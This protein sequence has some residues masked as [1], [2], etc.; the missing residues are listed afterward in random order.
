MPVVVGVGILLPGRGQARGP[1]IH[2][3]TAPCPYA[4]LLRLLPCHSFLD[5]VVGAGLRA[6]GLL[7]FPQKR[8]AARAY[9]CGELEEWGVGGSDVG[10]AVFNCG[11]R[12]KDLAFFVSP[13]EEAAAIA[14]GVAI[15]V[16]AGV[17]YPLQ[18]EGKGDE[19]RFEMGEF[20]GKAYVYALF[21][22]DGT[23]CML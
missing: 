15:V 13:E 11:E 23:A 1:R 8:A 16:V 18:E 6:S 4:A 12:E 2:T 10:C 5:R 20:A 22:G 19:E 7:Y 3:T 14:Q 21:A 9:S 17:V